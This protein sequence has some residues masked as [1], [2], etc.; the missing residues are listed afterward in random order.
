MGIP[1]IAV[2][3]RLWDKRGHGVHNN[4]IHRAGTH[5]C[6]GDFKGLFPTIRLRYVKIVYIHADMLCIHRIQGML[7]INKTCYP[8]QLL[9]F[10]D[11]MQR[12]RSL[13]ARFRP[14]HFHYAPLGQ[15]ADPKRKIQA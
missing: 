5:H 2:N 7:R 15:P 12:Y 14:V 13:S 11:H 10:C 9:H 4:N 3:F 1:H 6:F 8:S